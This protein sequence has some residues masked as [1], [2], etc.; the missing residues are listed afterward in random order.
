MEKRMKKFLSA[1]VAFA[2]SLVFLVGAKGES[3]GDKDK[4]QAGSCDI[5]I[6]TYCSDQVWTCHKTDGCEAVLQCFMKCSDIS[7]GKC[8]P[9]C[10]AGKKEAGKAAME[11]LNCT[12]NKCETAC[13]R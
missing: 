1:G 10:M 3:L 8:A 2:I 7:K 13:T 4:Y 5:C 6:D 12:L 11:V 9:S